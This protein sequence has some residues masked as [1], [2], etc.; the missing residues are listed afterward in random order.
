[1]RLLAPFFLEAPSE[2]DGLALNVTCP[3]RWAWLSYVGVSGLSRACAV[4]T[5]D[6]M[7]ARVEMED[8]VSCLTGGEADPVWE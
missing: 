8:S 1:M 7:V 2:A 4:D 6:A 5:L 3:L